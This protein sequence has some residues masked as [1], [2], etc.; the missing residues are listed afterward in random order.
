MRD[1]VITI[2]LVHL[3]DD[4]GSLIDS[5]L[6]TGPELTRGEGDTTNT[7]SAPLSR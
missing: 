4:A 5:M 3:V 7:C 1:M 2:A 6:T